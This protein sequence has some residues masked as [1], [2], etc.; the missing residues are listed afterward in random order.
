M[1]LLMILARITLLA[2]LS[3]ASVIA[4]RQASASVNNAFVAKGKKY[5]GTCGDQGTLSNGANSAVVVADFGQLTP[6]NS[7]KW[8]ATERKLY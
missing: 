8:D 2:S 6:E 5:F 7:L 1:V 4:N 3:S